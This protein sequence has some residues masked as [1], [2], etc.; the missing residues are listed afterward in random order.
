MN[1]VVMR[2]GYTLTFQ[3]VGE[4]DETVGAATQMGVF[5][6]NGE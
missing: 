2:F 3:P 4:E 5:Q 1:S 6:V